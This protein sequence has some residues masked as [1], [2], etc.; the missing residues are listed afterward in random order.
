MRSTYYDYICSVGSI[1][2]LK[3]SEDKRSQSIDECDADSLTDSVCA[4]TLEQ[5]LDDA[6]HGG[7]RDTKQG[8]GRGD[9]L[10]A[11]AASLD[12]VTPTQSHSFHSQLPDFL[13]PHARRVQG[14]AW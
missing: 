4:D 1:D 5:F 7:G 12:Q 3:R 2:E 14:E 8:S 10:S 13:K 11:V 6:I 9:I